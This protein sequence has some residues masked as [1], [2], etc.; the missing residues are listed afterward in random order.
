MSQ[1]VLLASVRVSTSPD[2]TR[3][4]AGR[5]ALAAATAVLAVVVAGAITTAAPA[6]TPRLP[7]AVSAAQQQ[8]IAQEVAQR[9]DLLAQ[10]EERGAEY[11]DQLATWERVQQQA[12]DFRASDRLPTPAIPNPGGTALPGDDPQGRA[13]LDSIGA[14]DVRVV[15]EAGP[16][17]CGYDGTVGGCYQPAYPD[18]LF[19]AWSPGH[20]SLAWPIF[21]HEAMHW[22]QY[23]HSIEL[24]YL[25]SAA[26]IDPVVWTPQWESDASCRA[27]FEHGIPRSTFAGTSAP[28]SIDGWHDQWLTEYMVGL[29]LPTAAP[30]PEAFEVAEVVRP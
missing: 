13:L 10:R 24:V 26:G 15:F 11:R 25:A 29:G 1:P 5:I 12:A 22:Y 16:E 4:V 19:M 28:C 21:V 7:T 23:E 14:T 17:N 3:R 8:L 18:A 30:D 27:V 2:G 20:R 9:A 6:P